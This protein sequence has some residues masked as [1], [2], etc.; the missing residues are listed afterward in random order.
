MKTSQ[1]LFEIAKKLQKNS[2]SSSNLEARMLLA[3]VLDCSINSLFS[4]DD[5]QINQ[6]QKNKLK[7][8]IPEDLMANQCHICCV[9][10]NFMVM[11]L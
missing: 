4:Q 1:L 8:L 11:N 6:V 9:K 5:L 2:H 3:Y 7:K 10:E